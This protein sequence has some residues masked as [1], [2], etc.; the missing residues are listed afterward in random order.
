MADFNTHGGYFAPAGYMKI[1]EGGSHEENPNGGVQVGVDPQGVPNMLEEG[2]PVYKDFVFSDNIRA[3]EQFLVEA[4]LPKH[5]AGKLYSEIVDELFA[6]AEERPNDPISRN[7]LDAMLGRVAQAQEDQKA[8]EEEAALLEELKNMSPEEVAALEQ[9]LAEQMAAEKQPQMEPD[10]PVE[11]GQEM[12][13]QEA[14]MP[15]EQVQPMGYACGGRLFARGG[16]E[17][18]PPYQAPLLFNPET[19]SAYVQGHAYAPVG[20][21]GPAVVSA[22][23][24]NPVRDAIYAG[25][26][27]FLEGAGDIAMDVASLIP[28]TAPLLAARDAY[29][30]YK[31][32]GEGNV[33][34]GIGHMA[35]AS[36]GAGPFIRGVGRALKPFGRGVGRVASKIGNAIKK[37]PATLTEIADRKMMINEAA[38]EARI[39]KANAANASE[40]AANINRELKEALKEQKLNPNDAALNQRV[41]DLEAASARADAASRS[42]TGKSVMAHTKA[43]VKDAAAF[44]V[45]PAYSHVKVNKDI[46]MAR[47]SLKKAEDAL[48]AA[49]KGKKATKDLQAA[50]DAA[51]AELEKAESFGNKFSH[52]KWLKPVIG[53][54]AAGY[55]VLNAAENNKEQKKQNALATGGIMNKFENGTRYGRTPDGQLV[56]IVDRTDGNG[57]TWQ[58][59]VPVQE[60]GNIDAANIVSLPQVNVTYNRPAASAPHAFMIPYGAGFGGGVRGG[61]SGNVYAV[62][63]GTA[64]G[65]AFGGG[66]RGNVYDLGILPEVPVY[67]PRTGSVS[68]GGIMPQ[69]E[70]VGYRGLSNESIPDA[71]TNE[72][73]VYGYRRPQTGSSAIK[74]VGP[75]TMSDEE[76]DAII[77][78]RELGWQLP[79]LPN[80]VNGRAVTNSSPIGYKERLGDRST[81]IESQ[82]VVPGGSSKGLL[83]D[84]DTRLISPLIDTAMGI[85]NAAMPADHYENTPIRSALPTGRILLQ[86]ER[87]MPMDQNMVTN[88][89][90]AQS[91]ATAR[92]LMNAGLG[93]SSAAAINAADYL[94]ELN[95]GNALSNVWQANNQERNRVIAANNQ[96]AATR[97]QFYR[98]LDS[99]RAQILNNMAMINRQNALRISMLNNQAEQN[100]YNAIGASVNA[101]KKFFGDY[102]WE[103]MNRNM[104]NSNRAFLGYGIDD[105]NNVIYDKD[106]NV[107]GRLGNFGGTLLK[108][109]KKK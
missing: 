75:A 60:A 57:T 16:D 12:M 109:H 33:A 7:G 51:K 1:N 13:P 25:Q 65:T 29:Q 98:D 55:G 58:E 87:Y 94:G 46:E 79:S 39:A 61:L 35:Y 30:A 38:N 90:K 32:F 102:G 50:V 48:A 72:A 20:E 34:G 64:N 53:T 73:V 3:Q 83:R 108:I 107:I 19:G 71:T 66:A 99:Q 104:V 62:N 15:E 24:P 68:V 81:N 59:Y 2:E 45:G 27:S 97:A 52:T 42:A 6:E 23:G 11:V 10:V 89:M 80:V 17:D 14:M 92:A 22:Y 106:G 105:M 88:Q 77:K 5:F 40:E 9:Q 21:I 86:D 70:V 100:K 49:K 56:Q 78:G 43:L 28:E 47:E 67:P 44:T 95:L 93:A 36:M 63:S 26:Q 74:P 85:Y 101:V 4:G 69:A 91:V 41:A 84:F 8:A 31:D 82:E 54:S 76:L 18:D 103:K 37:S 96:N